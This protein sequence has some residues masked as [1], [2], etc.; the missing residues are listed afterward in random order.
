MENLLKSHL[1][2]IKLMN[3]LLILILLRFLQTKSINYWQIQIQIQTT[4]KEEKNTLD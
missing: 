1:V 4:K 3:I 2:G